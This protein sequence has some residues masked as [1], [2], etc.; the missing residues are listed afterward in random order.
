LWPPEH[1][2][3]PVTVDY[4]AADND[5]VSCTLSVTSNELID[6]L[7]DGDTSPDWIVLDQHHVFLRA[8]RSGKGSGRTYTIT[9]TCADP[10]GNTVTR[11][12]TVKVPMSQKGRTG[13]ISLR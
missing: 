3:I 12:V 2:L 6:G 11:T 4:T 7:G 10:A 8:E 13:I 1:Q 9:V 5:S